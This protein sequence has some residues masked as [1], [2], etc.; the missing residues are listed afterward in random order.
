[1]REGGA[2]RSFH[3]F[4]LKQNILLA[5]N[6]AMCHLSAIHYLLMFVN[7]CNFYFIAKYIFLDSKKLIIVVV[8]LYVC[9]SGYE[10]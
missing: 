6:R 1:M 7:I 4:Y 8:Q 9:A 3:P 5:C 10:T 2:F